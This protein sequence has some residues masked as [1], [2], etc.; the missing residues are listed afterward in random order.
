[1]A[2]VEKKSCQCIAD[3]LNRIGVPCAYH[4]DERLTLR[5]KRKSR[6]SGL[7]R[8]S[9][10]RNLLV[11]STYMGRHQ[12]GKRSRSKNRQIINRDVP[13]IVSEDIWQRAQLTLKANFLFGKRGTTRSY[14]LRGLVKCALCNLTYIVS[15]R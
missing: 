3:Y 6:T 15:F 13:P 8:P 11:S 10:V 12:W 7:W 2:A 5:G 14:L 4:R 9:R 1:M